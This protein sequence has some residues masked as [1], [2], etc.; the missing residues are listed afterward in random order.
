MKEVPFSILAKC[1]SIFSPEDGHPQ[2][3]RL[4]FTFVFLSALSLMLQQ[5][6]EAQKKYTGKT[7][8][9]RKGAMTTT[10]TNYS[11]PVTAPMHVPSPVAGHT[12]SRGA[13]PPAAEADIRSML[14]I[15]I[16]RYK[17]TI[18]LIASITQHDP[19]LIWS[20]VD[21]LVALTTLD[22]WS[23]YFHDLSAK[24]SAFVLND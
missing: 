9:T 12:R 2:R 4:A 16:S 23:Q 3:L 15:Y 18:C 8:H 14:P 5:E 20:R 10:S 17:K 21:I 6:T 19:A 1:Y 13:A 7:C 24:P 11:T 22:S